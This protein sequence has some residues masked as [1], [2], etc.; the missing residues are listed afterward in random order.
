MNTGAPLNGLMMGNSVNGTITIA[1][2]KGS[3]E[4]NWFKRSLGKNIDIPIALDPGN[5]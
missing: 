5:G 1:F 3:K 4:S 2:K